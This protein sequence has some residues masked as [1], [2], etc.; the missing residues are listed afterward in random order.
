MHIL[1]TL[2]VRGVIS[3]KEIARGGLRRQFWL[4]YGKRDKLTKN[5]RRAFWVCN[6]CLAILLL[7]ANTIFLIVA[8]ATLPQIFDQY[9]A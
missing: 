7:L 6:G 9:S 4:V 1:H 5:E 2:K 8:L 3:E